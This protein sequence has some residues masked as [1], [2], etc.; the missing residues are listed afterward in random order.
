MEYINPSHTEMYHDYG[1]C[2][3]EDLDGRGGP[4]GFS[5]QQQ[6]PTSFPGQGPG[7]GPGFMPGGPQQGAG[8]APQGPPPQQIPQQPM[9]QA[10]GPQLFAVDPGAIRSCLF[11]YTYIWINRFQSFWFYP[12]YVGR[13]SVAGYR[14]T[15]FRWVYFGI[16]LN[17]IQSFT[18]V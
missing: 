9:Q 2:P 5:P 10:Q 3:E 7:P 8:M 11:R 12:T 15:G 17:R 1:C 14:W 6:P 16:D 13:Q 4:S 18:C